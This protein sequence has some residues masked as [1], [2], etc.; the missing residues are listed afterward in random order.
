MKTTAPE[1]EG[2]YVPLDVDFSEL[3]GDEAY[4]D[5]AERAIRAAYAKAA[6]PRHWRDRLAHAIERFGGW[7]V[8]RAFALA[9]LVRG[10]P[11]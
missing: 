2:T 8:G 1:Q 3:L 5:T 4:E 10:V 11:Y 6:N 7:L 9:D